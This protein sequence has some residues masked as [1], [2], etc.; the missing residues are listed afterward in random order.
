MTG[1][2]LLGLFAAFSEPSAYA[3]YVGY[4]LDG[5]QVSIFGVVTN[6]SSQEN[7]DSILQT[8]SL[9]TSHGSGIAVMPDPHPTKAYVTGGN[10]N[11]LWVIDTSDLGNG[12]VTATN[13]NQGNVL[14]LN[15][16]D[17]I[18]IATPSVGPNQGKTIAFIANDGNQTITT[19]DTA[20]NKAVGTPIVLPSS[21]SSLSLSVDDP[22]S[23]S[24]VGIL[25][26]DS[27]HGALAISLQTS[28]VTNNGGQ[29][30]FNS[31]NSL[32]AKTTDGGGNLHVFRFYGSLRRRVNSG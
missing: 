12:K 7:Q 30:R 6:D 14:G 11:S 20:T 23:G 5:S 21:S 13:I 8:V 4:A 19:V 24:Y 32:M 31:G 26:S 25:T 2:F 17:G 18:V 27:S 28:S 3:Q 1:V 15:G 22:T 10:D 9:G 29:Y 16:P